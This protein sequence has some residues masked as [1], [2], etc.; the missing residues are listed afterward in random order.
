MMHAFDVNSVSEWELCN[1]YKLVA[2]HFEARLL[3]LQ[4]NESG[5]AADV[6]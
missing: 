5:L 3:C 4:I 2:Q 6:C 1:F